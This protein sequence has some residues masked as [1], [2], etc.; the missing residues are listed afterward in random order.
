LEFWF[1]Q[2]GGML[3]EL[4][5]VL[6]ELHL[7]LCSKRGQVERRPQRRARPVNSRAQQWAS[8]SQPPARKLAGGSEPSKAKPS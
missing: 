2:G 4:A 3:G 7:N 8:G 1:G 5:L 6:R